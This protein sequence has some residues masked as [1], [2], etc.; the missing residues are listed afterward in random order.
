M[1][2]ARPAELGLTLDCA[3]PRELAAFWSLAL[4]Y[5]EPDPPP[6]WASWQEWLVGQGVPEDEWDDGAYLVDPAGVRPPLSLLRVPEPKTAKNRLHL[7]LKVT[8]GR[9]VDQ[10]VRERLIRDR[11]DLLLRAG[12]AVVQEV[13]GPVGLDHLV[14]SDPEGNEFCV[15]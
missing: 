2:A 10:A 14:L 3:R 7:D 15:V 9:D 6:G 1:S 11:A 12:A 5:V 13:A 8:G 4:G